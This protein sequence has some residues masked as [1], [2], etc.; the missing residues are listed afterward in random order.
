MGIIEKKLNK[1]SGVCLCCGK[2]FIGKVNWYKWFSPHSG[3]LLLDK[4]C[5]DC[6]KRELGSRN[7]KGWDKY[8]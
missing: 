5:K 1:D 6:A 8:L 7:K 4:I 3:K 2:S